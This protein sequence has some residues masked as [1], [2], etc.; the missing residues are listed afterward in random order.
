MSNSTERR[1]FIIVYVDEDR[2]QIKLMER[3]DQNPMQ[4]SDDHVKASRHE[5]TWYILPD[6]D[7]EKD[8]CTEREDRERRENEA[9]NYARNLAKE[10]GIE[11]V[12]QS[13]TDGILD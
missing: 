9:A 4:T 1:C 5:W 10:H 11:F 7:E 2:K 13:K 6:N 12:G 8:Y 3:S